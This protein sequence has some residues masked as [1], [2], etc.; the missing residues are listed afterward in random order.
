MSAIDIMKQRKIVD[1][2]FEGFEQSIQ[3]KCDKLQRR[4]TIHYLYDACDELILEIGSL[5]DK[6]ESIR[7][8]AFNRDTA[9]KRSSA[10]LQIKE[11][12]N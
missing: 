7:D 8:D 12:S 3:D 9:E 5:R 4:K 1:K 10:L 6:W 11:Y 2:Y